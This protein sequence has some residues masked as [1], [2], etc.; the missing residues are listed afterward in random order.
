MTAPRKPRAV[1]AAPEPAETPADALSTA[2]AEAKGYGYGSITVGDTEHEIKMSPPMLLLSELAR[3]ETGDPRALGV[4]SEFFEVT[5]VDYPTFKRALYSVDDPDTV[6]GQ[7]IERVL[8]KTV[9]R[10]TV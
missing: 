4:I 5:L 7:S 8:E 3:T 1:K 10:P 2:Q 9:G 6:M